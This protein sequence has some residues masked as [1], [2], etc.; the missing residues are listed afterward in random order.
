MIVVGEIRNGF[1]KEFEFLGVVSVLVWFIL[2]GYVSGINW[3]LW[4]INKKRIVCDVWRVML[5]DSL[6]WIEGKVGVD[7]I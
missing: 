3:I 2:C 1:F 6:G 7:M 4:V 5:W